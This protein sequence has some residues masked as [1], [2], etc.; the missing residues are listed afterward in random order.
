MKTH[1]G[2][3]YYIKPLVEKQ[4]P[5]FMW[6]VSGDDVSQVLGLV[7]PYLQIK[8]Q[9]ALLGIKFRDEW[10]SQKGRGRKRSLPEVVEKRA[11]FYKQMQIQSKFYK[12]IY[13]TVL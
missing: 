5:L 13:E 9:Q 2:G 3:Y 8:K 12:I 11:I 1:F 6:Q 7:L 10:Q 4:K